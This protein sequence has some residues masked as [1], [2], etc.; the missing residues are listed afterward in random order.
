MRWRRLCILTLCRASDPDRAP[1][2]R[3]VAE[4][5]GAEGRM[6]DLDD[7]PDQ[8]PLSDEEVRAA[9]R[10]LV[11]EEPFD[12]ILTHGPKGEYTRHRRHEECLRAVAA[13]WASRALRAGRMWTFAY[14][15]GGGAYLPRAAP[16]ADRIVPLSAALRRRKEWI[17]TDLYGFAPDGFEARVATM[18]VEAFRNWSSDQPSGSVGSPPGADG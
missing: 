8:R 7:G 12:L 10:A 13:L 18:A 17:V 11:P 5:Y 4:A 9:V 6:G 1:K 15:D 14:E 3:R 16:D 2:F